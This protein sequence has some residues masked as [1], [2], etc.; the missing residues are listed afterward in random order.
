[1][2]EIKVKIYTPAGKYLGYFLNPE[3][4]KFPEFEYEIT[5]R[6]F[7]ETGQS[8]D[9]VE[10]NPESLPYTADLSELKDV[11]HARLINVYVQ[12]GRQPVRI[13]GLGSNT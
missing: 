10:F 1:M 9:K 3:I 4:E 5:G 8:T 11:P 2:S 12:R 7:E 6:F 13:S